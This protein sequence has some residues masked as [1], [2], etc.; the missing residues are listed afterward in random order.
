M[1]SIS[2]ITYTNTLSVNVR[3]LFPD[4]NIDGCGAPLGRKPAPDK[5]ITTLSDYRTR[6]AQYRTDVDLAANHQL[7]AWI[8]TWD[9][10][11]FLCEY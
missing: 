4:A 6:I 5:E 3:Q 7:F 10:V 8:P 9:D 1:Y 11:S 2:A